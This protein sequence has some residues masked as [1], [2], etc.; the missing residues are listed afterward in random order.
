MQI[1]SSPKKYIHRKDAKHKKCLIVFIKEFLCVLRVS[2]VNPVFMD[3]H[4]IFHGTRDAVSDAQ[5]LL[6][7]KMFFTMCLCY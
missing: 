7:Y 5:S 1:A 4:P 3:T 6:E 2:A